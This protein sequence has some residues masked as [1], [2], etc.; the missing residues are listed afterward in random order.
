M[1]YIFNSSPTFVLQ[2]EKLLKD[3]Y[4]SSCGLIKGNDGQNIVAII[5]GVG[6]K[7]MEIWNPRT[8]TVE[9]ITDEIPAEQGATQGLRF[10]ELVTIKGGT[11]FILY[12]G[13]NEVYQSGI[14]KYA[15]AENKWTR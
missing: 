15:V 7:G 11:E 5:G 6:Q 3:R 12:G 2:D 4:A 13:M 8:K 14:W 1:E 9:K 10:S